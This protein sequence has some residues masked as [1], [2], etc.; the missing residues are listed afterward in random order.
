MAT[1]RAP[2]AMEIIKELPTVDYILFQSEAA[3]F[4]QGFPYGKD[5]KSKIKV[6]GVEPAGANC[7]QESIRQ[8]EVVSL[9]TVNKLQTVQPLNVLVTNFFPTSRKMWTVL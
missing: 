9:P 6:I 5:V 7:M 3:V 4:A 1:D 2:I 8:G